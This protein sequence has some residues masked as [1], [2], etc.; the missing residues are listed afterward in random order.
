ML[1]NCAENDDASQPLPIGDENGTR[2][3][4]KD[5]A[6]EKDNHQDRKRLVA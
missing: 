4:E 6:V 3:D 2:A 1:R 5:V